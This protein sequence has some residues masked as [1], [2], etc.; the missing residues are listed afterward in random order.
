M[1]RD[2]NNVK[3]QDARAMIAHYVGSK[4]LR[5]VDEFFLMTYRLFCIASNHVQKRIDLR[6]VGP[7]SPAPRPIPVRGKLDSA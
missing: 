7:L 4:Y 3:C 2:A 6:V 5:C 1:A